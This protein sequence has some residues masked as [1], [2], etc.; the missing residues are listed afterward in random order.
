MTFM[1]QAST[2]ANPQPVVVVGPQGKNPTVKVYTDVGDAVYQSQTLQIPKS[3]DE[4]MAL[5]SQRDAL[6]D[7]LEELKDQR[8]DLL[9]Q[10]RSAPSEGRP[11]LQAQLSDLTG[12]IVDLQRQI[13]LIGREMAGAS[14]D[15]I[16][17]TRQH[18]D[19]GSDEP[20]SFADG[21]FLGAG[22]GIVGLTILFLLGRWIW[23]RFV[24]DDVPARRALPA[25]DSERL[26]RLENGIEA[27][28][29]EIERISEGQRYVT[30]LMADSRGL[31]STPR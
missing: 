18:E 13:T 31:E 28:A 2:K 21:I 19:A 14:P 1:H 26:R 29:I 5:M 8:H 30:K 20:G 24:R 17:M 9:E 27:M 16:A 3:H 4:M 6:T 15:L 22:G 11:G 7:Q 12:Q 25:E 23:K 10:I